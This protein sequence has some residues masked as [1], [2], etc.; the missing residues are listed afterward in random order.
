M[1]T[2][3]L[4]IVQI[5][6]CGALWAGAAFARLENP[7]ADNPSAEATAVEPTA[8]RTRVRMRLVFMLCHSLMLSV[9]PMRT[10]VGLPAQEI[11]RTVGT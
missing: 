9:M 1:G 8:V 10:M 6:P 3:F 5:K 7:R 4:Y 2:P 11:L